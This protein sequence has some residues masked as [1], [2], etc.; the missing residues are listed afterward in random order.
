MIIGITGGIGSGKSRVARFW[1]SFFE[2]PLLDLDA[3]CRQLMEK[4]Q[5]GWLALQK[6]FG[7]R[8][9]AGAGNLDRVALRTAIFKNDS[10]RDEVNL[11]L[12][13]LARSSM[14]SQIRQ[15]N[16]DVILVEIPLLFEAGWQ[17]DVDRIVVVYADRSIRASRIMARDGVNEQEC[18]S[19]IAAQGSVTEKAMAADYVLDNS[20]AWVETCLQILHLGSVFVRES[21][22]SSE[23]TM[24]K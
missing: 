4:E 24:P 7:N 17:Q 11:V 2:L 12:H 22:R 15:C 10:L 21:P 1:S 6:L 16:C 20:G 9:F 19:A 8:F 18:F 13:P 14:R 5:P 23:R 3:I